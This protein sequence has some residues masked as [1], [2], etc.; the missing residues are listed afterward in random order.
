LHKTVCWHFL[1]AFSNCL[2]VLFLY[3]GTHCRNAAKK[4]LL[5]NCTLCLWK[6]RKNSI[7]IHSAWFDALWLWTLWKLWRCLEERTTRTV[8]TAFSAFTTLVT[9]T[10]VSTR[11]VTVTTRS[12]A[13]VT[14][15]CTLLAQLLGHCLKG[16]FG[17]KDLKQPCSSSLLLRRRDGENSRAIKVGF[18]FSADNVFHC[19]ACGHYG[20]CDNALGLKRACCAPSPSAIFALAG[21]FDL[22]T[23]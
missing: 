1:A 22:D 23:T 2:L 16:L 4:Y 14:I 13:L 18:H 12:T 3:S 10:T 19:G 6:L 20:I 5:S 8:T 11:F 7:D 21:E 17:R 15:A 9:I